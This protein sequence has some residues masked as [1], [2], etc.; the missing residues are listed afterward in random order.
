MKPLKGVKVLD[1]TEKI[2]GNLATLYL[3]NY[4]AEI[5]KIEKPGVGDVTRKWEPMKNGTSVYFK[6]LNRGKKSV[7]IDVNSEKGKN[8]IKKLVED[9][10][11]VCENFEPGFMDSI[12]LGYES[13]K[14]INSKLI[15]ASYSYFGNDG[16]YKNKAGS[17]TIAQSLGVAM[18]MTGITGG[19]PIKSGP[20][21]GEHYSALNLA[22]GIMLALIH[23]RNTGEGQKVDVSL[24][25]SIFSII[26]AAPVAYSLTGEIQTRKGNFDPS[27]A[28]YDTFKTN[29]GYIAVGA[30]TGGQW[31]NFCKAINMTHLIEDPR[32]KDNAGRC[33]DYLNKLRPIIEEYTVNHSKWEIEAECR[34][35]GV[36]CGSILNVAQAIEHPQIIENGI[37][38]EV[39]DKK[40]GKIQMPSLPV[41]LSDSMEK[42]TENA[43]SLGQNNNEILNEN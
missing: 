20:S 16:P 8:I 39:E 19:Y 38:F 23:R 24:L 3:S 35:L 4:G 42:F 10:D 14:K 12:G 28:P 7:E 43:P 32:F 6:Y 27:C 29:D 40:I 36:P 1:F 37:M 30:A 2:A 25:D 22:T 9:C 18:D 26:E 41:E 11:V 17:S 31:I 33:D 13:L 15:F 21:V 5:I 34:K